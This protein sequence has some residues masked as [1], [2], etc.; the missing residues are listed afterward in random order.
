MCHTLVHIGWDPPGWHP[1]HRI[2]A[3]VQ[4]ECGLVYP[5]FIVYPESYAYSYVTL[6]HPGTRWYPSLACYRSAATWVYKLHRA[7]YYDDIRGGRLTLDRL[8][9]RL[10]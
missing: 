10:I 3:R 7:I 6:Y 5:V 8:R 9:S 2:V 4:C 1:N